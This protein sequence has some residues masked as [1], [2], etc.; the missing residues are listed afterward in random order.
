MPYSIQINADEI[1]SKFVFSLSIIHDTITDQLSC[2]IDASLDLFNPSTTYKTGQQFQILLQQL[3]T[4][5]SMNETCQ[6]IHESSTIL[7]NEKILMAS[8]N[9]TQ[10]LF[11]SSTHCIQHE[12]IQ[13]VNKQSQKIAIELDEQSLTCNVLLYYAQCLSL[14]FLTNS[15]FI[16][17]NIIY[18][19]IDRSILT[20]HFNDYPSKQKTLQYEFYLFTKQLNKLWHDKSENIFRK[21]NISLIHDNIH[22]LKVHLPPI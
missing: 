2:T 1:A 22:L 11:S 5:N 17:G 10:T 14:E 16:P 6:S 9:N 13:Q 3:F 15:N 20:I 12:F 18:Q 19:C 7:P 21:L 4:S 8:M